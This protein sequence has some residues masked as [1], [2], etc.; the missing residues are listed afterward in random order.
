MLTHLSE[1]PMKSRVLELSCAVALACATACNYAPQMPVRT[2]QLATFGSK[3]CAAPQF[4]ASSVEHR[5]GPATVLVQTEGGSG[6]GFLIDDGGEQLVVTNYHVV[7]AGY[8]YVGYLTLPDGSQHQ[9]PL[10]L[11]IVTRERDLALLRP[12]S[13]FQTTALSLRPEPPVVGDNVAVLGYPGV[14]GSNLALTFEPGTVTAT[15][16][17]V[18]SLSYIQTNANINHG[19]SGGP[20]VDGCSRVVGVVAATS[21]TTE[22]TGLVI[23]AAAVSELIVQ[24]HRPRPAPQAAAQATLQKLFNEVKFRRGDRAAAYFTRHY[25]AQRFA[26]KLQQIAAQAGKKV[27]ELAAKLKKQ[28]KDLTKLPESEVKKQL[29]AAKIGDEELRALHFTGEVAAK[30]SSPYDAAYQVLSVE[31]ADVFGSIDDLW[32]EA[33]TAAE[34]G[35]IDAYVTASNA[36]ETRRYIAHMH[37]DLGDWLVEYV[38]Q[39]R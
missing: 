25:V 13:K 19:N 21:S 39:V 27:D 9:T 23:P 17:R 26:P 2:P 8:R 15:D 28:G 36:A 18:S 24:Y 22:R 35:G 38:K 30:R 32:V 37:E 1:Y 10:E 31:A 33:T 4:D 14:L 16:R 3:T 5:T 20:M 11:M 6:S 34:D 29:A 7:A 12:E